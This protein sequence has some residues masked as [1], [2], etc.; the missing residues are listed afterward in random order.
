MNLILKR[1]HYRLDGIFSCLS[2]EEDTIRFA[3]LEHA[4]RDHNGI[5]FPLVHPGVYDCLLG[6]HRLKKMPDFFS[7]FEV[8]GVK[9]H[10]GILFHVGNYD[11]DS[12]GC[13]LIGEQIIL[14]TKFAMINH[15]HES[16]LKFMELQKD[17]LAF[18]LT[19]IG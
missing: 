12:E 19:V 6:T 13:I 14:D 2:N 16:Y 15:S 1:Q 5:Y 18:R 17:I 3:T 8:T 4:Y 7:T 9:G 10:S 11:Q